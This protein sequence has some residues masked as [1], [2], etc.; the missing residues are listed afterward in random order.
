[1]RFGDFFMCACFSSFRGSPWCK[2]DLVGIQVAKQRLKSVTRGYKGHGT[3]R[4]K[5]LRD[6]GD[7]L[8]DNN[9]SD[10]G[11][12]GSGNCLGFSFRMRVGEQR[13]HVR[14]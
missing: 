9:C 6:K 5:D 11:G 14:D 12:S 7:I 8:N 4:V 2:F 1:M 10:V 3:K 13:I